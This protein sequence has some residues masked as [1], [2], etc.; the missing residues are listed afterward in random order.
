MYNE[1]KFNPII[2]ELLCRNIQISL[3]F[4]TTKLQFSILFDRPEN[5]FYFLVKD[6]LQLMLQQ[7]TD[8][9]WLSHSL[10]TPFG[11]GCNIAFQV[12]SFDVYNSEALSNNIY[13][14]SHIIEYRVLN[15]VIKAKQVIFRDP[16]GYLIRFIQPL[17]LID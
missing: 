9:G 14:E 2:P 17:A 5:D 13:L 11:N 12:A 10:D 6:D 4:Y 8:S 15:K 7:V 1:I 16:D 3:L